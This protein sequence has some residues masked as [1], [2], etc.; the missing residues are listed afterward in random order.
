MNLLIMLVFWRMYLCNLISWMLLVILEKEREGGRDRLFCYCVE[1]LDYVLDDE[2]IVRV[3]ID[4][5]VYEFFIFLWSEF[6]SG[7]DV[8]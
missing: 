4:C 2:G 1:F 5:I 3:E 7:V 6:F 8:I